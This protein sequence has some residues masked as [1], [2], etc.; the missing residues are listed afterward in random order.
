MKILVTGSSGQLGC[1]LKKTFSKLSFFNDL[2]IKFTN[3]KELDLSD[4]RSCKNIISYYKPDWFINAAAYTAVDKAEKEKNLA[5]IVN[6]EGPKVIAESLNKYGG[7]FLQISTDFVFSGEQNFPYSA[8]QETNPINVYGQTKAQA[9]STLTKIMGGKAFILRTSWLYSHTGDNFL[10]NILRLLRKRNL[11]GENLEIVSDQIGCPT[12]THDLSFVISKIIQRSNSD[13]PNI[14]Q[15]RDAG[16][17]T[18][19]DF[20]VAIGEIGLENNLIS[21]LPDIK[22]IKSTDYKS[23]AYRPTYSVLSYEET[24]ANINFYPNHWRSSLSK[25]MQ[26]IKSI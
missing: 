10:T 24:S 8:N 6:C 16:I 14:M 26:K 3:R 12:N 15:W 4:L 22:P 2:E 1:S 9:E 7:K 11:E 13:L 23:L 19:Y 25:V 21:N 18:W 17:A 20:A 5:Q